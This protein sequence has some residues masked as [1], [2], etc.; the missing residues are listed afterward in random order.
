METDSCTVPQ[1]GAEGIVQGTSPFRQGDDVDVI[2]E[3]EDSLTI[4]KLPLRVAD[5]VTLRQG[6]KGGHQGVALFPALAL[7]HLMRALVVIAPR[8]DSL[9]EE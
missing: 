7:A 3:S 5:R 2:E 4:T 8:V 9:G 6:I 1:S